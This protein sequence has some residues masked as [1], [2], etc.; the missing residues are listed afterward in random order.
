MDNLSI[1]EDYV[2]GK[3]GFSFTYKNVTNLLKSVYSYCLDKGIEDITLGYDASSWSD[4]ALKEIVLL[5]ISELGLNCTYTEKPCTLFELSWLTCQNT[6]SSSKKNLGL[7]IATDWYY[8]DVISIYFRNEQGSAIS[9]ETLV[10]IV[11][12]STETRIYEINEAAEPC[13]S[14]S[15]NIDLYSEYLKDRKLINKELSAKVFVD[16]MFGCVE[17]TLTNLEKTIPSLKFNL[18]NVYSN[19]WR[20]KNYIARPSGDSLKWCAPSVKDEN[21]LIAI[22]NIGSSIGVW[23]TSQNAEISPTGIYLT[24]LYLF[25]K[26]YKKKGTVI[27]SKMLSDRVELLAKE[28]GFKVELINSGTDE[29]IKA[30]NK[31]R[32]SPAIMYGDEFG[33]FWFKG[34]EIKDYNP[35]ITLNHLLTCYQQSKKSPGKQVDIISKKYFNREY[36]YAMLLLPSKLKN[37]KALEK[38]LVELYNKDNLLLF[39]NIDK[40]SVFRVEKDIKIAITEKSKQK[41]L[42]IFIE[43]SSKENILNTSKNINN[44]FTIGEINDKEDYKLVDKINSIA[45]P[46][47]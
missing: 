37:K 7:Y 42:V 41:S 8:Q 4:T 30:L 35:I 6:K 15:V 16:C 17:N 20:L 29:F 14:E 5:S 36:Q 33:R 31:K 22:D 27:I 40:T 3:I 26:T 24:L 23:D 18:F 43:A 9:T 12:T 32:R 39:S 28:L 10:D 44:L 46:F 1:E 25:A 13:T 19:P 38:D 2:F 21:L 45:V 34:D 47:T 11:K